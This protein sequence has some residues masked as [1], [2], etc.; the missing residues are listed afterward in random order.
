MKGN[1]QN[2]FSVDVLALIDFISKTLLLVG[3]GLIIFNLLIFQK[4]VRRL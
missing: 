1:I 4:Y 2:Y 3:F